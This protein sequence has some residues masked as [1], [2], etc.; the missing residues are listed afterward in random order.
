MDRVIYDRAPE[1]LKSEMLCQKR[2]VPRPQ[3]YNLDLAMNTSLA[4]TLP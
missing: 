1:A 3:A 2:I 4:Y